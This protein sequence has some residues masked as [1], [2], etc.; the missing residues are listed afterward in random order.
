MRHLY[1]LLILAFLTVL[2]AC[3]TDFETVASS[4][5]LIFSK[6]T[7]YLDTVFKNISSSTYQLKVYNQSKKDISIPNIQFENG[8]NSK[9]RM[10]VDGNT[11][12][13]GKLFNNITLLAKDSLYI[14]IEVTADVTDTNTD[15]FLYTDKIVF[16]SG[17]N[18][19]T[20]ELVTLVKDAVFLYPQ[21]NS[22]GS[23]EKIT[24]EG[25]EIEGFYLDENDAQ[26]GNE[27]I[28]NNQKPYVIY[29]YA[30][31]PEN[32]TV[33][34]QA[35]T[36]VHFHSNSGLIVGKNAALN[37]NGTISSTKALENE[38]VFQGDRLQPDYSDLA[39]QWGK[40]WLTTESKT[41]HINH[42]TLKNATEGLQIENQPQN[43]NAIQNTQIYN[44]VNYGILASNSNIK[45]ENIVINNSGKA[46]LACYGGSY[47]FTHCTFNNN[48]NNASQ[49]S[50]L[51][52]NTDFQNPSTNLALNHANFYNCIV[53]GT[54]S[55]ELTLIKQEKTVFNYKF[56]SVLIKS[57]NKDIAAD[58]EH[59]E[60]VI[61]NEN[62][63]FYNSANNQLTID[64]TSSAVAKGNTNYLIPIDI[65][66]NNRTTPPDLGAYQNQDFPEK[67]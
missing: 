65:L 11:G 23:K 9:Y 60:N 40:I 47:T 56:D 22:D 55:N 26:N 29:G 41:H 3:R 4:G 48:W 12:T 63:K 28:F 32:K 8:L 50:V 35:G 67:K 36:R 6:D 37:I 17:E 54:Y 62:P 51:L 18:Q 53:Y 14:F 39:G 15:D 20:V 45:A 27:L 1:T 58:S 64:K 16:D 24:V 33:E 66:G 57:N 44:C 38:V 13:N 10:S 31:V 19:Q 59:F 52:S 49:T 7:V 2:S 21:K 5:D 43:V 30:A 34:F 25:Q 61:L 42:L 46:N